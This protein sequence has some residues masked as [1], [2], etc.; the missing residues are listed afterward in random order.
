MK[1][2][3]ILMLVIGMISAANAALVL[4]GPTTINEGDTVSI[5]IINTDGGDYAA[6]LT[7]GYVS[8]GGFVLCDPIYSWP[9]PPVG[10]YPPPTVIDDFIWYEVFPSP[11]WTPMA[12]LWVTIDLTCTLAGVD[13][14]VEL[15]DATSPWP[16]PL[17]DSLT[18]HQIPEPITLALLGLGG[19]MLLRRRR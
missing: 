15:Y 17:L 3:L 1:K 14:F 7:F 11:D 16:L 18:I 8:E 6:Y 12:G 4:D 5:E 2:L 9:P 10:I 13:V 19:L